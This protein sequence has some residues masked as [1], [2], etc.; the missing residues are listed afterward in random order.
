[1]AWSVL[2]GLAALAMRVGTRSGHACVAVSSVDPATLPLGAPSLDAFELLRSASPVLQ[3]APIPF[4]DA[5]G[6]PGGCARAS[7]ASR[8]VACCRRVAY[9]GGGGR[10]ACCR[11]WWTREV[12]TPGHY[13]RLPC[14]RCPTRC[15]PSPRFAAWWQRRYTN[16]SWSL[17]SGSCSLTRTRALRGSVSQHRLVLL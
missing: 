5:T 4:P 15:V 12:V 8:Q 11:G 13:S 1:M 3:G 10:R 17:R 9:G 2:A 7:R 14:S 16:K 6:P